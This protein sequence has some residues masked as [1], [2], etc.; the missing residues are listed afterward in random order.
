LKV[1][2]PIEI[3]SALLSA[4]F[5]IV[6]TLFGF[7]LGLLSGVIVWWWKARGIRHMLADEVEVNWKAY[8]NF[9]AGSDWPVRSVYIWQSLQPLVPG[10]LSRTRVKALT[11]FYYLQAQVYKERNE[12]RLLTQEEAATLRDAAKRTLE[13]LGRAAAS[14]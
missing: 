10:V 14:V 3:I 6:A 4:A 8:V 2:I 9:S 12:H 11:D 5:T 1:E 7:I 13:I